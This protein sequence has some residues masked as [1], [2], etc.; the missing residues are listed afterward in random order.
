MS[1]RPPAFLRYG[2]FALVGLVTAVA[3]ALAQT[4]AKTLTVRVGW[5]PLAGGS[6][7]IAMTMQRDHLYEKAAERFGYKL[8]PEWKTFPAGPPS[9]EAMVAG[10]LDIDM[11]LSALPTANRIASEIP[12][13][14]IAMV[15]SN[16]ANAIMVRPGSPINDV[17]KLAGKTIGLPVG[18]SAHYVLAS[19]IQTHFGKSIEDVGI[20]LVNMPVTEAVKIPEGIDA[21]GVWVPLRFIGPALGISE[22]LVDANGLTGKGYKSPGTRLPDVEKAWAYP[23]GY[24]TDRL[25][26]FARTKFLSENPDAVLA[27]II[28]HMEA[29]QRVLDDFDGTVTLAND[30]WKQDP[31]VAKTT[32]ETYAETAGVRKA[33]FLLEWDVAT[34]VKASE[35]LVA[36]RIRDRP[37]TWDQLKAVFTKSAALQKRAWETGPFKTSID[38]MRKGFSGKTDLYGPIHINGGDPVWTWESTPDWGRRVLKK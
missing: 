2:A 38:D 23:E 27:F 31:I 37:L 36:T 9:N 25:Y 3:T 16:I 19:I 21:A 28:A 30:T 13:V 34:L 12:A 35:F 8:T 32:L 1:R 6:A 29:Q 24:N 14:P 5:Q 17:S 26:A 20:R 4:P 33:P 7:A 11:H 15:G 10:H 22:L 18:T